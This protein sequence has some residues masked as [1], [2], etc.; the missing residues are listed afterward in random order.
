MRIQINSGYWGEE[1]AAHADSPP[2]CTGLIDRWEKASTKDALYVMGAGYNR[3]QKPPLDKMDTDAAGAD[4]D[5]KLLPFSDGSPPPEKEVRADES[6]M[7]NTPCLGKSEYTHL[8]KF[9]PGRP[10]EP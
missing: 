3:N 10:F 2:T 7:Y 8:E 1:Y 4:L 5:L 6:T 9:C